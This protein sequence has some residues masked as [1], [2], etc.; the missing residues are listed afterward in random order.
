MSLDRWIFAIFFRFSYL[1]SFGGRWGGLV[2]LWEGFF[3]CIFSCRRYVVV[4]LVWGERVF[5]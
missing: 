1:E 5:V 4:V 3:V 2:M